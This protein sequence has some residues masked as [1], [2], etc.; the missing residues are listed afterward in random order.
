[1]SFWMG[2]KK[3]TTGPLP[4]LISR[5]GRVGVLVIGYNF[6]LAGVWGWERRQLDEVV[7]CRCVTRH[8]RHPRAHP[9]QHGWNMVYDDNPPEGVVG[10]VSSEQ[11]WQRL[12][13]FLTVCVPAAEAAGVRLAAHPDDPPMP[14]LR[15]CARLVNQPGL[16]Q[17]L[18]DLK[19]S[20]AN[21]LE[22]CLGSLQETTEGN[23][24]QAI[25]RYAAQKAIGYIHFRNVRGQVPNYQEVFID[26]GDLDMVEALR[27][28]D[29]HDYD[30][31]LIRP[32]LSLS[33]GA[34]WHAGMAYA[35]G[36]MRALRDKSAEY[37]H[38]LIL[39]RPQRSSHPITGN[40]GIGK[41]L[42]EASVAA[43][44][45]VCARSQP[46]TLQPLI[47]EL[48]VTSVIAELSTPRPPRIAEQVGIPR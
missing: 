33:C 36:Y 1:M 25:D 16:Y 12:E 19:P 48:G 44:A 35:I 5:V 22:M 43:G 38:E 21:A 39:W 28:L 41:A 26:E 18:L 45:T 2:R 30:G 20:H 4:E 46:A 37:L 10:P 17:K 40:R 9:Q 47:D 6:S 29:R 8:P 15:G 11:I 23:V 42:V 27:I 13:D 14:A 32:P 3:A 7:P 24:I 31:V 34:P